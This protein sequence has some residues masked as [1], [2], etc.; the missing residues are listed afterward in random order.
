MRNYIIDVR[1]STDATV[2][3]APGAGDLEISRSLAQGRCSSKDQLR[4]VPE[5]D[6]D[7]RCPAPLIAPHQHPRSRTSSAWDLS[8]RTSGVLLVAGARHFVDA[9]TTSPSPSSHQQPAAWR[10]DPIAVVFG[11]NFEPPP[12]RKFLPAIERRCARKRIDLPR[13]PHRLAIRLV[14]TPV[15]EHVR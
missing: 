4:S 10:P 6:H 3:V 12:F 13:T 11:R 5:P 7:R 2:A 9:D 14:M 8:D 15:V 1:F